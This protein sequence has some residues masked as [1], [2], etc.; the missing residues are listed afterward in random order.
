MCVCQNKKMRTQENPKLRFRKGR[1]R[2]RENEQKPQHLA[3]KYADVVVLNFSE[4]NL[5]NLKKTLDGGEKDC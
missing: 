1:R 5:K 4:K 2:R 3:N